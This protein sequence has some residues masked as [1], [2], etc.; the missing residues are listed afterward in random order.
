M[1]SG[2]PTDRT[3]TRASDKRNI[4]GRLR[5]W[6]HAIARELTGPWRTAIC[7]PVLPQIKETGGLLLQR[8]RNSC[9]LVGE[10][11]WRPSSRK[12]VNCSCRSFQKSDCE[13]FALY[14]ERI[15]I[16]LFCSQKMINSLE[17][18]KSEFY[19]VN[20]HL[21][22]SEYLRK[23][24]RSRNLGMGS[25]IS[26]FALFSGNFFWTNCDIWP[27]YFYQSCDTMISYK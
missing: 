12:R 5:T 3:V 7:N 19:T 27:F 17:K 20:I 14:R 4:G 16:S 18:P 8:I 26:L 11:S 24:D 10:N 2:G 23:Q 1:Y 9:N 25:R 15:A 22:A 21:P 13:R 6:G